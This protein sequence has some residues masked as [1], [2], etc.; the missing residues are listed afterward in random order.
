MTDDWSS[1][2]LFLSLQKDMW[3]LCFITQGN[4]LPYTTKYDI[5]TLDVLLSMVY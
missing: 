3:K 4:T 5:W 2:A 1:G